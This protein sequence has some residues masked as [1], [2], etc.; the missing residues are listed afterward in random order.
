[1]KHKSN[2]NV[3]RARS[4]LWVMLLLPLSLVLAI[5]GSQA[6]PAGASSTGTESNQIVLPA[7]GRVS[8]NLIGTN[9]K[10]TGDFG[11]HSPQELLIYPDYLYN[12]GIPF[13][14][15][16]TFSAGTELIF[17]ISPRDFCPRGPY[18]STN[19][20]RAQITQPGANTWI[21]AWEDWSDADYNDLMV[22]VTLQPAAI[23]FL[24][25][26]YD[27]RGSD[28]ASESKVIEHG[29]KV[30]GYFD[31]Q[32][33]TNSVAPNTAAYANT[34]NLYGYDREQANP[35]LP[36]HV[37]YDGHDGI[38][39]Y[40]DSGTPILAAAAGT[41]ASV[42]EGSRYCP[43]TGPLE[44]TK[45]VKIRH[46]NGY[47]TEYWHLSSFAEGVAPGTT[48]TRDPAHP[49]GYL[50]YSGCSPEPYLHFLVRNESLIAV[51]PYGWQPLPDAA[52]CGQS[53]RWRQYHSDHGGGD[54]ESE[55]LWKHDLITMKLL[56]RTST[57]IIY[58]SS[59]YAKATLLGGSS[60]VALRV[61]MAE[62]LHAAQISGSR[63]I[64]TFSLFGF[65]A[66]DS[67][68]TSLNGEI[69]V[70]VQMPTEVLQALSVNGSAKPSL[71]VWDD[72]SSTWKPLLT[73]W[74]G[75]NNLARAK[76]ARIGTF[77][78]TVPVPHY[79]PLVIATQ[80]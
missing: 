5:Y 45:V 73:T 18:L 70:V 44:S 67:P 31:H 9:T 46:D 1:M 38:D 16:G 17:Y 37:A 39:Y 35:R 80:N 10:C 43:L 64:Y 57:T 36:Y 74:I 15:P 22:Q 51:D 2:P 34:V 14:I 60:D 52:W 69:W 61:Q 62:G 11:L 6:K 77:A 75:S 12:A 26:P 53:N 30:G 72:D 59:G 48:V 78:L 76:T 71:Q 66:D 13:P 79:I 4:L 3:K 27:Y 33:P 25:L 50:G 8:V 54:A 24:D 7:A 29:G 58:S 40:L 49:I 20:G 19:P 28:F 21:I 55:T 23:A 56:S 41:V 47:V 32:Y 42:G 63:S 65:T 68:V